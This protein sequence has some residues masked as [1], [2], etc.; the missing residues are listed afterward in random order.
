MR[1]SKLFIREYGWF[2]I[3]SLAASII[4]FLLTVIDVINSNL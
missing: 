3:F 4:T 1:Q 2:A